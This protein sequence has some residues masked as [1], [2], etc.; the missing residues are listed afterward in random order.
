MKFRLH[1]YN[2]IFD[3]GKPS[4]TG[5]TR[6]DEMSSSSD[7]SKTA[8]G[9]MLGDAPKVNIKIENPIMIE[10]KTHST[11]LKNGKVAL[12]KAS[13]LCNLSCWLV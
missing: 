2:C 10:I 6:S 1:R 13:L 9:L 12:E 3:N 11:Y 4:A 5:T 8:L 7:V